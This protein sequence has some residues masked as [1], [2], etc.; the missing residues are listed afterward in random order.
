MRLRLSSCRFAG[1]I[2]TGRGHPLAQLRQSSGVALNGSAPKSGENDKIRAMFTWKRAAAAGLATGG[3]LYYTNDNFH[4]LVR[5]VGTTSKRVSVVTVATVRCCYQYKRTLSQSYESEEARLEALSRCHKTCAEITLHALEKNG[6]IF[7]KLGQHIGAMTYLLPQEWTSTMIPLQDKCPQSTLEE[8]DGMFRHDLRQGLDELFETFDPHPIGVASL[9]QVHIA[10]LKGSHEK[11]AVKCQHPHLKEFVPLDVMLTQNVFNVLDVVFPEY[12]M[13]WLSDELQS[14]I[15]VELDFTK[16]AENAINTANYFYK[17]RKETAL[18][19]P[20]VVS[21]AKRILVL[22][23]VEGERLDNLRYLDTN[24]ISR[25]EVS[26]CLSHIFNNMIF[27]PNVGVHCDPHGG[28]LAIRVLPKPKAGHNFEIVLYDH[29]LYRMPTTEM[30]R[31]YAKFWLA[32]LDKDTEKMKLYA[33]KFAN[34]K[35]EQFPIFAAAIT[36]R[37]IDT[38]LNYDIST[39][40]SQDEIDRMKNALLSGGLLV[41][42]MALLSTIPRIVL[43]ILKTNDLTRHLDECLENPL[44]PERTFLI[45]T[46][47][48]ARTIYQET[49][50]RIDHMYRRWTFR[51]I[52]CEIK[53]WLEYERRKSQLIIFDVALWCKK[54][55]V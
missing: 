24:G 45:L 21:A 3:L 37:S 52:F 33:K 51:W 2:R 34:V 16:E 1:T 40:R 27:T 54:Y 35:E 29:G 13:T 23:F 39:V 11:V 9:A 26:S 30:R 32:L 6:G 28:N 31:D 36:G 41:D 18:R 12:P 55:F 53:A 22:E 25:S 48:C 5:H 17:Y 38:A 20:R 8:I 43:L 15:Y 46:Q 19:I 50:E 4:D 10:T 14:S 49:C 7:I 47:Y 44:G 42:I